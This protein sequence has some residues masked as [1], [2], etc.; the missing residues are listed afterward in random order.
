MLTTMPPFICYSGRSKI[1]EMEIVF[2][3]SRLA[4][5]GVVGGVEDWL[6]RNSLRGSGK[7]MKLLYLD[8]VRIT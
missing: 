2:R 8:C 4:L 7:V 3:S 6:Q 5:G 1:T